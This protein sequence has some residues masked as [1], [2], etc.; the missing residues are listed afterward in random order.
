MSPD[1]LRRLVEAVPHETLADIVLELLSGSESGKPP[2]RRRSSGRPRKPR[3]RRRGVSKPNGEAPA[4]MTR[5]ATAANGTLAAVISDW[6]H[7]LR[8]AW[9]AF[10]CSA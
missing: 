9:M 8:L 3:T 7:N 10:S 4:D 1:L 6:V 5:E 2:R